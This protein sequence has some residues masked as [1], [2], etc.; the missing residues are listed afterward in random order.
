[1]GEFEMAELQKIKISTGYGWRLRFYVGQKREVLGLG[2]FDEPAAMVAKSHIEHL[3]E[4]KKLDRPPQP[5]TSRWLSKIPERIYDRLAELQLVMPR[6]INEYPRTMLAF[7]RAYIAMRTDWKK[8]VNY[9]QAVVCLEKF[10]NKKDC[11]LEAF[12]K[13]D[14]ER[15]HRVM[16]NSGLSPNTAGQHI[17]RCRQ[18]MKLALEDELITRNPFIG[19]KIDLRSDVSKNRFV[20]RAMAEAVLEACPDQEW[21]V[22]F[23]LARYGGLRCPSE[24][25]ALR[26]S[27]INW[28]RN[29]FKVRAS[30]TA[31]YGKGER[32]VPLWPELRAE[33]DTLFELMAPGTDCP[34]D[35]FV[36]T[37][38]R[39]SETNLRTRFSSIIDK[40]GVTRWPKPFIALRASRRTELERSGSFANHVLNEWFGHSADVADTYY[41]QVTE[42]DFA[43]AIRPKIVLGGGDHGSSRKSKDLYEDLSEGNQESPKEIRPLKNPEKTQVLMDLGGMREFEKY[44]QQDSNLQPSAS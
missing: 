23:A 29:R 15:W 31:R 19:V 44:T 16:I 35:S 10:L 11:P 41:L 8:P 18:M 21:R 12:T 36:I 43:T 30:K 2:E 25:L 22:L 39:C 26:W 1:L 9:E 28:E 3:I 42:D 6:K 20:D 7:M 24:V 13:G 33:L 34:A 40:A 4:V 14:A 5:T 32:I 38:Y 17:K 37:I 27:D